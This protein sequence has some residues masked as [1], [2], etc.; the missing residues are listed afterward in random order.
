MNSKDI[1]LWHA[2]LGH[3][4]LPAIKHIVAKNIAKGIEIHAKSP[5]SCVCE[6]CILGKLSRKPFKPLEREAR[7]KYKLLE[8]IHSDIV[9]PMQT[10]TKQGARYMITFTEESTRWTEVD[11]MRNK[12]EAAGKFKAYIAKVEKQHPGKH[13]QRIRVNGGV[14]HAVCG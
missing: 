8:L 7:R 12:S 13:V 2:R 6:A 3:L 11:Y 1:L 9:G 5:T 14:L 4:A 10:A